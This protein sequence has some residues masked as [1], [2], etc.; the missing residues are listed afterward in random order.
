MFAAAMLLA[1]TLTNPV[2]SIVKAYGGVDAW[3]SVHTI[4]ETGKVR[5]TMRG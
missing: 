5:T 4:R 1:A 2:D 3:A